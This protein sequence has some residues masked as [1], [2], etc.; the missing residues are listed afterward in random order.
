MSL[1]LRY[2]SVDLR[3]GLYEKYNLN[4][5]NASKARKFARLGVD[6]STSFVPLACGLGFIANTGGF[7]NHT[8]RGFGSVVLG[9]KQEAFYHAR[10]ASRNLICAA[11]DGAM[12]YKYA[13]SPYFLVASVVNIVKPDL[14]SS[15]MNKFDSV[16][17]RIFGKTSEE[18]M[19][20][21]LLDWDL[22]QHTSPRTLQR[23]E[24][25]WAT[26]LGNVTG[27]ANRLGRELRAVT[28]QRDALQARL[29][30]QGDDDGSSIFGSSEQAR[31]RRR[32]SA[33][34]SP[35]HPPR[36]EVLDAISSAADS[37]AAR[38]RGKE[39]VGSPI[40]SRLRSRADAQII[41]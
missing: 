14:T 13:Y 32:S 25:L 26:R 15:V 1:G 35:S 2:V 40:A 39:N 12:I 41:S 33:A 31:R 21:K 38:V 9:N 23:T 6:V 30:A 24:S 20:E 19:K 18:S 8:L 34:F 22:D 29:D 17:R 7:A 27:E 4:D 28:R 10:L 5:P 3:E 16:M 11:I 37:V 36:R